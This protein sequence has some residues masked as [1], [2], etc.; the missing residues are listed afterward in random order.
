VTFEARRQIVYG[1]IVPASV[2]IILGA[3]VVMLWKLLRYL[4]SDKPARHAGG[5]TID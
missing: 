4:R 3:V 1:R 5:E 2:A